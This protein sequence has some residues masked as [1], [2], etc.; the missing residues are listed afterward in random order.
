MPFTRFVRGL[1]GIVCLAAGSMLACSQHHVPTE[2]DGPTTEELVAFYSPRSIKILP[3]T[4]PASFDREDAIP[5]GIEVSLRALDGA[6]DP[7]KAYGS[8]VFELFPF[9]NATSDHKGPRV[10]Q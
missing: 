7:V 1:I 6:G 10:T 5:D 4:K 8:F 9:E 3:F 2:R